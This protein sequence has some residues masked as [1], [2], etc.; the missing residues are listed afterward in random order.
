MAKSKKPEP[1]PEPKSKCPSDSVDL[2]KPRYDQ[3]TYTGRAKTFFQTTNPLNLFVSD[4]QLER[5]KCIVTKN[6]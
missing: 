1:E 2:S 6:R 4:K 3:E 5:A